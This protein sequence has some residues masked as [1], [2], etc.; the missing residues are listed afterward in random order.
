VH[1]HRELGIDGAD[2]DDP[3]GIRFTTA[4]GCPIGGVTAPTPP[5]GAPPP[6][7]P[8]SHPLGERLNAGY[9]T[10]VDPPV[11]G[12]GQHGIGARPS[13]DRVHS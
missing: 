11:G 9:V 12:G 6:L 13:V 7:P 3:A 2:A 5:A 1:H 8:Y 10:F 4:G